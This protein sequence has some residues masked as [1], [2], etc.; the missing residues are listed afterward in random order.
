[1]GLLNM[2]ALAVTARAALPSFTDGEQESDYGVI[3]SVSGP[4]VVANKMRGAAMYELVRVGIYKLVGEIIRLEEDKATIQVYEETAGCQVGD[5]VLRTGKPLSVEL[6]PGIMGNIVTG[7]DIIGEVFENT[8]VSPRIMVPPKF[9]GV[10]KSIK[11]AGSYTIDE[12]VAEIEYAGEITPITMLQSW[13]VRIPRPTKDKLAGDY[14]LLT[15]Q[16]VLDALF[17]CVQGGTTAIPGA[18]GCGKTVISQSLSK[19]S[20]SDCIV[21]VGCG[22]RGNEMAEVLMDFPQLSV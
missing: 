13:P 20:N 12:A 11:S 14:P 10:L 9:E 2:S 17:P 15:G 22:E 7:G 19:Y 4:V 8:L 5:P 21:Y 6:G 16:R 1:M 18:F 3:F